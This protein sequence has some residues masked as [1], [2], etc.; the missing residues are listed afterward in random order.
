MG[1]GGGGHRGREVVAEA[2]DDEGE[3]LHVAQ[4]LGHAHGDGE[5]VHRL[6]GA[7]LAAVISRRGARAP[8]APAPAPAHGLFGAAWRTQTGEMPA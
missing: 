3:E 7:P 1:G 8:P 4:L 5:A 6:P 2:R